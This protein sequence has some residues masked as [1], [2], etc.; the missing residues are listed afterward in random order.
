[1]LGKR[2]RF[3]INLG[4]DENLGYGDGGRAKPFSR[5]LQANNSY[6]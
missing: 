3:V 1:M 5:V 6:N 4:F 2:Y